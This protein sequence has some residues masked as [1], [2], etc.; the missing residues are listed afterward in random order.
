MAATT[1]T[2][3]RAATAHGRV[4]EYLRALGRTVANEAPPNRRRR[5][6]TSATAAVRDTM[7]VLTRGG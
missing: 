1:S 7:R 2:R 6:A 4:R 5:G 3:T